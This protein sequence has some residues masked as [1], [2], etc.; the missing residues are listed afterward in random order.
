MRGEENAKLFW[1][2]QA[3]AID[4]IEEMVGQDRIECNFHRLDGYLF[5]DAKTKQ[6]D[7]DDELKAVKKTGLAA[8]KVKGMPLK[9][10]GGVGC[11]RY[12]NQGA[13]VRDGLQ[14]VAAY[15]DTHGKLHKYSAACIHV[16]CHVHWNSFER[17]WDCPCHGSQFAT[18]GSALNAPAI[19]PLTRLP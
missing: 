10:Y 2:S 5:P 13:I 7:L 17:C 15:R 11:L 9:G 4:R 16:G 18:D 6:S 12:R 19:T 1:Q 8:E 14:K 3:A